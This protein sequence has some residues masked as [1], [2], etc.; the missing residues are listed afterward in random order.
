MVEGRKGRKE[1]SESS[2]Q[3]CSI[4][5]LRG[6]SQILAHMDWVA[7]LQPQMHWGPFQGNWKDCWGP[8]TSVDMESLGF[9][10]GSRVPYML[11]PLEPRDHSLSPMPGFSRLLYQPPI[12]GLRRVPGGGPGECP[13][14]GGES[15]PAAAGESQGILCL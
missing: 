6:R 4:N 7:F 10:E 14:G 3:S 9:V 13:A 11:F 2:I 8:D 12:S 5:R 15:G 1:G